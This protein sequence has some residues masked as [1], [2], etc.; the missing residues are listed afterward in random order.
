MEAPIDFQSFFHPTTNVVMAGIGPVP[1]PAL[2]TLPPTPVPH[3]FSPQQHS[4]LVPLVAKGHIH[5]QDPWTS[6][7]TAVS[8]PPLGYKDEYTGLKSGLRNRHPESQ[9]P[10][11]WSKGRMWSLDDHMPLVL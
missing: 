2:S 7:L 11:V 9:L 6:L 10:M 5:I 3:S 4:T 1:S 8:C